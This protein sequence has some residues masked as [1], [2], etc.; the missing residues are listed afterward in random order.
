MSAANTVALIVNALTIV[1]SLFMFILLLWQDSRSATNLFFGILMVMGVIWSAGM[2]LG[3]VTAY[4]GSLG[5]LTEW[6]VRLL[7][8]GFTGS[9]FGLYLFTVIL[10]GGQGRFFMRIAGVGIVLILIYQAFL[11][12]STTAPLFDVRP[13]GTLRYTFGSEATVIYVG[14]IAATMGVA[15]QR[16]RKIRDRGL[17]AVSICMRWGC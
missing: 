13:D 10:S 1:L 16:R 15:V 8:I 9:C 6:G 7:R 11:A 5:L 2:L 12:F 14:F 3:R 4:M 17:L